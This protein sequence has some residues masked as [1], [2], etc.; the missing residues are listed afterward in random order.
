MANERQSSIPTTAEGIVIQQIQPPPIAYSEE[1]Q[2][3]VPADEWRAFLRRLDVPFNTPRRGLNI[4]LASD[5]EK[6]LRAGAKSLPRKL[7]VRVAPPQPAA[8]ATLDDTLRANG[9][10]RTGT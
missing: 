5:L 6:A 3:F 4:V 10:S 1:N 9:L 8:K 7:R 2:T